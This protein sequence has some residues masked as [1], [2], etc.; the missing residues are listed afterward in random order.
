MHDD[1]V[2]HEARTALMDLPDE[3]LSRV[4]HE[5]AGVQRGAHPGMPR[6]LSGRTLEDAE[7]AFALACTCTR[8]RRL[9]RAS[10]KGVALVWD[11][12]VFINAIAT[13]FRDLRAV[14]VR[15]H[16]RADSFLRTLAGVS[17]A[18][19]RLANCPAPHGDLMTLARPGSLRVLDLQFV[20]SGDASRL[21]RGLA[22]HC[23]SLHTL[24]LRGM[25]DLTHDAVLALCHASGETIR[26]LSLR[27]LRNA[28]VTDCTLHA[29][30]YACPRVQTLVLDD[31]RNATAVGIT[32]TCALFGESLCS[33]HV[34]RCG[35]RDDA[36]AMLPECCPNLVEF[37][38]DESSA[39]PYSGA[40]AL[41]AIEKFG[42]QLTTVQI[43]GARLLQNVDVR[44]VVELAPILERVD[45]RRNNQLT[46]SAMAYISYLGPTLRVLNIKGC[47]ITDDALECFAA[48]CKRLQEVRL[49]GDGQLVTPEG[50]R[51]IGEDA[52]SD[53]GMEK[54][55]KGVGGALEI[56]EF[57]TPRRVA[58]STTGREYFTPVGVA[59]LTAKALALSLA[60]HCPNLTLVEVNGL[61]PPVRE[62][63]LRARCELAFME[64]EDK[65]SG[66]VVALDRREPF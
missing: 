44:R 30:A 55:L 32:T 35:L 16:Q 60:E 41:A 52:L 40:G 64:L 17:L 4:L 19:L 18:Q 28:T 47:F 2:P 65:L 26:E 43:S 54:F 13:L 45:V 59:R 7:S 20:S 31:I 63:V 46:D 42:A 1:P 24:G 27:D 53:D 36:I 58:R 23:R 50:A 25:S 14:S 15:S 57:E 8:L 37:G 10:V 9:F 33:L 38:L 66:V 56:F 51:R 39:G 29:V 49:G 5:L 62:R 6:V 34:L 21:V 3:L 12:P 61:R 48:R 11:S 22:L